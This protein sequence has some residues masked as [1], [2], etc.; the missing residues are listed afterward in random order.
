MDTVL[1]CWTKWTINIQQDARLQ[2][3]MDSFVEMPSYKRTAE[4]TGLLPNLIKPKLVNIFLMA[5]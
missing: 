4:M 1:L 3:W 2:L 5:Q